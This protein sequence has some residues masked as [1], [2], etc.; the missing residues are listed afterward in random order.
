MFLLGLA[1]DKNVINEVDHAVDSF[2]T[3]MDCILRY[4][5]CTRDAKGESFIVHKSR[6]GA[7]GS[8][9]P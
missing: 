9:V 4:F 3:F 5:R 6:M 1:I 2:E 8:D 7:K